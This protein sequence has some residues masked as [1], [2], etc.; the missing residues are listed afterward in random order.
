MVA[1]TK[2]EPIAAAVIVSRFAPK[3]CGSF[4]PRVIAIK[5]EPEPTAKGS[6]SA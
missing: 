2:A 5:T 3:W 1:A 6:V 4:A